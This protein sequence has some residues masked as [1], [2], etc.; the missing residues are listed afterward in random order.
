MSEDNKSKEENILNILEAPVSTGHLNVEN[1]DNS[2]CKA[3]INATRDAIVIINEQGEINFWNPSA[4]TLFGWTRAEALGKKVDDLIASKQSDSSA[5]LNLQELKEIEN[6]VSIKQIIEL[7][8]IHKDGHQFPIEFSLS[9]IEINGKN[10]T[11]AT[12][13]DISELKQSNN[14]L[15]EAN[16]FTRQILDS[17]QDGI[18]IYGKDLKYQVWNDYMEKFTGKKSDEI[19]GKYPSE[20]FPFLQEQGVIKKI[21]EVLAGGTIH[22][23]NFPYQLEQTDQKGWASDITSPLRNTEGEI[24][25]AMAIVRDITTHKQEESQLKKWAEVFKNTQWGMV[26]SEGMSLQMRLINPSFSKMHGYSENELLGLKLV[27]LL[28]PELATDLTKHIQEAYEKGNHSFESIHVRKD[29]SKFSTRVDITVV[30]DS[31]NNIYYQVLNVVDITEKNKVQSLLRESERLGDIGRIS[32]GVA[33]DFN[34]AL[35]NIIGCVECVMESNHLSSESIEDLKRAKQVAFDAASRVKQLQRFAGQNIESKEYKILNLKSIVEDVVAQTRGLWKDKAQLEG[36]LFL[37][38]INC[39]DNLTVSGNH[40]ELRSALFNLIKNS[41]ESMPKGGSINIEGH[42]INNEVVLHIIDEGVGMDEDTKQ[43][44]FQPF[45]TTKGYEPGRGLGMS[46]VYSVIREHKGKIEII[47]TKPAQGTTFE[48]KLPFMDDKPDSL[49]KKSDSKVEKIEPIKILWVD[50]EE[51][52]RKTA[53]RMIRRYGHQVHSAEGG[54]EALKLMETNHYDLMVTD[55]GMPL[56]SGYQLIEKIRN[57]YPNI[58]MKIVIASGWGD[59][60]SNEQK[61]ALGVAS[62][63]SKP[64]ASD[65]INNIIFEVTQTK[66]SR[67]E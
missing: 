27:D 56:M 22:T 65:S 28:D 15:I 1:L 49:L 23:S 36:L 19:L 35:Q 33:H 39:Q 58:D 9:T 34:N 5:S 6:G 25:G 44:V 29:G 60:I 43:K 50:D 52:I 64:F 54:A 12:I 38:K 59:N 48:I 4:E 3:I 17:A 62:V 30:R 51:M 45:F 37:M 31:E 57:I 42:K 10:N 46:G 55:L 32:S 18:I 66:A 26:V 14:S 63:L 20:V 13:R 16:N 61:K 8:A 11:L 7:E 47:K 53:S 2:I 40:G 41:I 21:E 24:V 67:I